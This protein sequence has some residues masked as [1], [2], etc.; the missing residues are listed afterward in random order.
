MIRRCV[1]SVLSSEM[2]RCVVWYKFTSA[3]EEYIAHIFSV[4]EA[5]GSTFLQNNSKLLP[6]TQCH[7]LHCENLRS[8][9]PENSSCI[10]ADALF[11]GWKKIDWIKEINSCLMVNSLLNCT[12]C[13]TIVS[14]SM[15]L[16]QLLKGILFPLW[17]TQYLDE[18]FP[19][20]MVQHH[21]R[22]SVCL[23]VLGLLL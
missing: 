19:V 6:T 9:K 5:E 21:D 12:L 13:L 15:S 11:L 22:K 1:T 20:V 3:L 17:H 16:W 8:S 7:S 10:S 14:W 4:F 18:V 23:L 2:W